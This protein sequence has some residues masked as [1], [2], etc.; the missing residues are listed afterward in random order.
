MTAAKPTH[1]F[2]VKQY[3]WGWGMPV[4]WQGWV[5]LFGYLGLVYAG[6]YWLAPSRSASVLAFYLLIITALLVVICAWKG[7]RPLRWR[8]GGE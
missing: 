1:W 3:G 7:E 2:A 5:V 6:I 4:R 8:W